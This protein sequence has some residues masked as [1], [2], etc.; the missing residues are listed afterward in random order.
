MLRQIEGKVSQIRAGDER[1]AARS[2]GAP[3][4]SD[5][6][7]EKGVPTNNSAPSSPPVQAGNGLLPA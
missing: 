5:H 6:G 2:N 3:S 4:Y 7:A 1:G